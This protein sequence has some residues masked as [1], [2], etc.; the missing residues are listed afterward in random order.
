VRLIKENGNQ[1][2]FLEN[3]VVSTENEEL[4]K[5]TTKYFAEVFALS[6]L[7]NVP[8]HLFTYNSLLTA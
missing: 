5:S 4:F 3:V 6:L 7:I 8:L 2:L 1:V